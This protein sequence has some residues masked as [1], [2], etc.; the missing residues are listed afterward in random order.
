MANLTIAYDKFSKKVIF[1]TEKI[2]CLY[3]VVD[4]RGGERGGRIGLP[5]FR[6][7]VRVLV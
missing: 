1:W 2:I 3:S 4:I 6:D 5:S 7:A